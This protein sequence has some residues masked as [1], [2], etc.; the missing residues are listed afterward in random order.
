MVFHAWFMLVL[1]CCSLACLYACWVCLGGI[2][3]CF[4][5]CFSFLFCL[6]FWKDFVGCLG[7]TH[8]W[9]GKQWPCTGEG[10]KLGTDSVEYL[11]LTLRG[12]EG[13]V[14]W[15]PTCHHIPC[16]KLWNL[17]KWKN[18]YPWIIASKGHLWNN[19]SSW[20]FSLERAMLWYCGWCLLSGKNT[21]SLVW[22]NVEPIVQN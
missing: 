14:L 6:N 16:L 20:H 12:K 2:V 11:L 8:P 7:I 15:T 9:I 3:K 17:K 10:F 1:W 4:L 5:E 22:F 19:V 13:R 21:F 18:R